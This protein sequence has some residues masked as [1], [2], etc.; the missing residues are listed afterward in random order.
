MSLQDLY[1]RPGFL[2]R[3]AH[4]ISAAVFERACADLGLTPAQFGVLSVLAEQP[5]IDQSSLARALA[6]DKVTVLR[7]LQGLE[8]R[9][10][11]TRQAVA[12]N[13]RRMA[14]SLS[15]A[16]ELLL[17]QA[18]KPVK[19]SYETLMSPFSEAER[20]QFVGLLHTFIGS[21]EEQARTSF[22]PVRARPKRTQRTAP[23]RPS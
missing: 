18:R 2:L 13:R 7:V 17:R 16:G 11:C 4:Q 21:L 19:D 9:G 10:L 5:G 23:N 3:R 20:A 6:F 8:R 12:G 15:A 22:V 14:V 1:Q